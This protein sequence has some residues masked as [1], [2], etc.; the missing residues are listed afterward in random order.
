MKKVEKKNFGNNFEL[1]NLYIFPK[2]VL[3]W[4]KYLHVALV[5][6][7]LHDIEYK[8]KLALAWRFIWVMYWILLKPYDERRGYTSSGNSSMK[9]NIKSY[10]F[11]VFL[12]TLS[13]VLIILRGRIPKYPIKLRV[14]IILNMTHLI[15]LD[16]TLPQAY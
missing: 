9:I 13:V 16:V 1:W 12:I 14:G 3:L 7:F 6:N 11:S 2:I 15:A 8:N 4:N 5:M 10:L